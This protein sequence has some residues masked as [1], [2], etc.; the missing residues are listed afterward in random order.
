MSFYSLLNCSY[1]DNMPKKAYLCT[2]FDKKVIIV[3]KNEHKTY[4]F[5]SL[6]MTF[7]LQNI[8]KQT[9]TSTINEHSLLA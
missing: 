4:I 8:N 1:V 6:T 3:V 5:L 2:T 9:R 7:F